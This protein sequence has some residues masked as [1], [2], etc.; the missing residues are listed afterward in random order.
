MIHLQRTYF[1]AICWHNVLY[2]DKTRLLLFLVFYI[3]KKMQTLCSKYRWTIDLKLARLCLMFSHYTD[4]NQIKSFPLFKK[5]SCYLSWI[6]L[7]LKNDFHWLKDLQRS[8]TVAIGHIKLPKSH[9]K[10]NF[11]E[12]TLSQS[13]IEP[14]P[15]CP[16]SNPTH[17]EPGKGSQGLKI[18]KIKVKNVFFQLLASFFLVF[19]EK[20]QTVPATQADRM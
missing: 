11:L 8:K 1:N 2:W 18:S 4:T 7:L 3:L 16:P 15:R 14:P 10:H 20:C 17:Y 9:E 5:Q 12:V 6:L 19:Q 13:M